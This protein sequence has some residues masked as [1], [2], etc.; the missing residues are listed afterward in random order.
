MEKVYI[1]VKDAAVILNIKEN[2]VQRNIQRGRYELITIPGKGRG[3]KQYLIAL[4]SLPKK[5][6]ERYRN[7]NRIPDPIEIFSEEIMRKYTIEQRNKALYKFNVICEYLR[8]GMNMQ[9]FVKEHSNDFSKSFTYRQLNYWEKQYAEHGIEGLIDKRGGA[10]AGNDCIP[11]EMWDMFYSLY[12]QPQKRSAQLCYDKTKKYFQNQL[13]NMKIPSYPTFTRKLREDV[14]EYAKIRYRDGKKALADKMPYMERDKTGLHTNQIWISDHHRADVFVRTKMGK[15]IRPWITVF[16]D[17]KSTKVVACIARESAP[18]AT[19]IKQALR[20]G[21]AE[22]GIPEEIYTDNG[23]DYISKEL[24]PENPESVLNLLK[25]NVIHALPYHGQ[26]KPVE[27][28][29]NTLE[30][31]FG[32][33]FY[34]YAGHDARKRPEHMKKTEKQLEK[35]ENIPTLEFYQEQLENYLKE[36]NASPHFGKD[37]NGRTPDEVYY[38]SIVTEIKTVDADALR[39]LCGKR[40]ERKVNNS[41]VTLFCNTFTSYEGEL[42]NYLN[43]KVSV[44]YDPLDMERVYIY[45]LDG[46]FICQ[47]FPKIRSPFRGVNEEDYIRAGKMRKKALKVTREWK[48]KKLKNESEILFGNITEEHQYQMKHKQEIENETIIEAKKAVS[49]RRIEEKFNPFVEL[50]DIEHKKGVI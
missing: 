23:K 42:L 46:R 19:V 47:A 25:I 44:I 24:D 1:T 15:I 30:S 2:S 28:F 4:D 41:G 8:S 40:E 12:M 33:L 27:R 37:M 34:S 21:I 38:G 48:P 3:G 50:F 5:A 16:T 11:P 26:A 32:T 35:D 22:Y 14:P 43:R 18:N 36:Y 45:S 7:Q 31:R 17:A 29:F 10:T 13:P 20:I 39:I 49:D 6:Q 9:T